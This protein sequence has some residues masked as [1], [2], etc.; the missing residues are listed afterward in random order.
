MLT[1]SDAIELVINKLAELPPLPGDERIV[2]LDK[3]I[4]KPFGW[5]FIYS[6]KKYIETGELMYRLYGNGP[7]IV[8]KNT[9]SVEFFGSR[10]PL[11]EIIDNYER[12]LRDLTP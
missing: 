10:I 9:G 5:V 3:T 1:K 6:S 7:V 2:V 8:N 12:Q 11:N 4:E